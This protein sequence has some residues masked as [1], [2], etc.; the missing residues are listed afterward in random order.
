LLTALHKVESRLSVTEETLL[1]ALNEET[2]M[3]PTTFSVEASQVL[4]Q[5]LDDVT[6]SAA[7]RHKELE[8]A[9]E[10]CQ[11]FDDKV[12]DVSGRLDELDRDAESLCCI[13]EVDLQQHVAQQK[14]PWHRL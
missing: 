7:E 3:I 11:A 5:R 8:T 4:H 6:S 14:V 1:G 12:L 9:V 2:P 10:M 13:P